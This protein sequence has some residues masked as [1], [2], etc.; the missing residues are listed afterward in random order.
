[1]KSS[2]KANLLFLLVTIIWGGTFPIIKAAVTHIGANAF[3][4]IRFSLAAIAL[5]PWAYSELKTS[6]R[7]VL[8][9]G[10][11]LGIMNAAVY[12]LQTASMEYISAS[13]CAFITGMNVIMVPILGRVLGIAHLKRIDLLATVICLI[14]LYILTGAD[15]HHLNR[16]DALV[17]ISAT[18]TALSIVYLHRVSETHTA[19]RAITFY[20]IAL[21]VPIPFFVFVSTSQ[22]SWQPSSEVIL[23]LAYCAFLA[24]IIPMY[25]QTRFQKDTTPTQIALIFSLE[26]VFASLFAAVFYHE[27]IGL[28][29]LLGGAI[30]LISMILP[31]I[32]N[33]F[34]H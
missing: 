30:M 26:P 14:G 15:F 20:Q 11:I 8:K 32:L 17:F 12:V 29:I 28:E 21:T 33:W 13:R 19:Y 23:A 6:S 7:S 3:V 22:F 24:T 9:A 1:M 2:T 18:V 31:L 4:A 16:G 34:K 10:L 27:A 25:A 5:L